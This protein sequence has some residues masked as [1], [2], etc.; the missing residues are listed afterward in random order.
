MRRLVTVFTLLCSALLTL[1]VPANVQASD[2]APEPELIARK[3]TT[4]TSGPLQAPYN[5][6]PWG[7]DRI[8]ARSGRDNTF[9]YTTDGTG[10]KAYIVDSGVRG[11]H[12]EFSG[13]VL[14]GWSYRSR[15]SDSTGAAL[16]TYN[17][18]LSDYLVNNETGIRP[19][20]YNAQVHQYVP[21]TFDGV[22]DDSDVGKVD[23]DGHGT[24]VAGIVG[25]LTTGVAKGVSIVPVRVLDSCGA[26][27]STMV[28]NGLNWILENHQPGER[29][30]VNMS[31][32]FESPAKSID[33]VIQNLLAEGVV[34]VAASGNDSKSACGMTPAGTQGTIS[35]G[36]SMSNDGEPL[37]TNFGECVDI[38]APGQTIISSWPLAT[39]T[40]A[41]E[42]GTSMSAPHVTGAVARYLQSATVTSTT[43]I[44][45]WNWLKTN[46]TCNA[47][48]YYKSSATDTSRELLAKTPNRLL[49]VEAPATVPCAPGNVTATAANKSSLVTWDEV[50]AGNGSAVTAYTAT[51]TTVTGAPGGGTCSVPSGTTCTITGLTNNTNYSISV[52]ATNGVGV[53]TASSGVSV[54]PAGPPGPVTGLLATPQKNELDVSWVQAEGDGAGITYTATATTVIGALGGG[55]CT[56]TET[57][58]TSCKI[59]GL[60][61]G[62]QYAVSVVG[63]NTNG[64]TSV[65]NLEQPI[66][67]GFIVKKSLVKKRSISSL[68]WLI[69]SLSTGKKTWSETGP[70][71]I[72]GTKLKAPKASGSCVITLKVAKKGKYPAMST[73]L[74]VTV[75]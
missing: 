51:A 45:S 71:S 26:G 7:I 74:R 15:I 38:Y 47:I 4:Q 37:F 58:R 62:I 69:S 16:A 32:G 30:V 52:T 29:A 59:S 28:L 12:D 65:T 67:P 11:T 20:A 39:N 14:P 10:V 53:G 42:T 64:V 21:S 25:G 75:S 68:S 66:R 17:R 49:A 1:A 70:C 34:V 44:D 40:Y 8:D 73:K 22:R 43:P 23:N 57:S 19:C 54:I 6:V 33:T 50:A 41:N 18:A 48:T 72:V 27:T 60:V 35:V 56:S 2:S 13:R 9:S 36:A 55:T 46:A 3:L 24:H 61:Y 63:T 31:I 5:A